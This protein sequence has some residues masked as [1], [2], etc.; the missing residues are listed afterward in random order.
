MAEPQRKEDHKQDERNEAFKKFQDLTK[1][2]MAVPKE[3]VDEKRE[4]KKRARGAS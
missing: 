1:K 2:L 4:Q 3:E